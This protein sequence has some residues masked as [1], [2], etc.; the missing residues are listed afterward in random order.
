MAVYGSQEPPF[1]EDMRPAPEDPYGIAKYAVEQDLKAAHEAFGLPY[2][3]FRPHNVYG[4]YQNIGDPYRNVVGIFMRKALQGDP[5]T[6]FGDGTQTRAF[7]Y[8]SDI[9]DPMV[10]S[11][12]VPLDGQCFNIGGEQIVSIEELA[13]R[14]RSLFPDSTIEH[15]P[16]RYEVKHAYCDH[17]KARRMLG[18]SNKVPLRLGL[19]M[20]AGWVRDTGV[21]WSKTPEIELWLNFPPFWEK[22]A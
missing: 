18:F 14:V 20:M 1:T 5:I 16:E 11:L 7:S 4:P 3:I 9:I 6:V 17:M 19:Q 2:V 22:Y 10:H 21:R 8:I 13:M 15:L 12:D